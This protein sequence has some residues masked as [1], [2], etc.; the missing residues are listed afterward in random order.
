MVRRIIACILI[1]ILFLLNFVTAWADIQ[2]Y[3]DVFFEDDSKKPVLKPT[4]QFSVTHNGTVY[5]SPVGT[6]INSNAVVI[7]ALVGDTV[8]VED[9]SHS[10]RGKALKAWDFQI[11]KPDGTY[12]LI[13]N[14][15]FVGEYTMSQVGK[16]TFS[17]CVRDTIENEAWTNYWGN[18]SDNGNHRVIGNNPGQDASDPSDD[19]DGYWYFSRIVVNVVNNP[20]NAGFTV[21][22]KGDD[23]TDNNTSPAEID[24][25]NMSLVLKDCSTPF[26]ASEPIT[27]R[28]WHY[29]DVNSGWKEISGSTNKTTVNISNI[30]SSLPGSG[31]NKA[32]KLEVTSKTGGEDYAEHTAYFKKVLA[33]GYI[34]YYRD[35]D[36]DRDI[37]SA[38]VV[39][40]PGFGTYTESAR[41]APENGELITPSPA[42]IVLNTEHPFVEFIFYYKFTTPPPPAKEPPTAI[43]ETP[44][45]VMAGEV[46]KADGSKSWSNNPGGYIADYYF[47]YEGANLEKDNGSDVRI[48]Y[49]D[50]GTYEIYLEVEDENG[51]HDDMEN[52][53]EVT[54]PIPTAVITVTGKLKE[55]RKVT[56][57]SSGSKSPKYYPIDVTNTTW[58]ITP[59]SGGTAEDIKYNGS[60]TGVE[61]KDVL[62]KK[63]GTYRINLTIRNTY[64]RTASASQTIT[65]A[66]DL[67]PVAKISLPTPAGVLY[68]TYRDPSDSN[69]ATAEI[70]NESYS[71]DGD[72]INKSVALY[73]Y[74]SDN[75]GDYKDEQWYYSKDGTTWLS[76]G[77]NYADTASNFNIYSIATSNVHTFIHKSKDV[78]MYW[79]AIRVME[80]IAPEDTILEF[81]VESDYKRAD[82]F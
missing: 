1:L 50:T 24:T 39:D 71:P 19:F 65:I 11:T 46:V 33:N 69:Y 48:W 2:D 38:K 26:S 68:R 42:A 29:W 73:C 70:F 9:L 44:E 75:D 7:N 18:W 61:S 28:K 10:N 23:V 79:Y 49:P 82:T 21:E 60:L 12:S 76:T 43:L 5:E 22:Y 53:I 27:S 17:L 59:I 56:I 55:N 63:A 57:S 51:K 40:N 80:T 41:P 31:I 37:F 54:P 67:P 58:T 74:D 66:K 52:E 35:Q 77:M 16:Y 72:T 64:G 3:R 20:P 36:T 47:E 13:N 45:E 6:D 78:G 25:S 32:F 14:Q 30:D 4:A 8:I 34:V 15:S 81:L 62:F